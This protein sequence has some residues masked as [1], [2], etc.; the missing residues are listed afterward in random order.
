[1]KKNVATTDDTN[2]TMGPQ[3]RPPTHEWLLCN[4]QLCDE[5]LRCDEQPG[6]D[7]W[8]LDEWFLGS[9]ELLCQDVLCEES[10]R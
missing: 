7:G 6:E 2:A 3:A 8:L 10:L 4:E 1:M 9:Q 5:L